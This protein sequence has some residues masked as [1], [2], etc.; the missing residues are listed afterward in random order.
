[1]ALRAGQ[2]HG[3]G[4][5]AAFGDAVTVGTQGGGDG[6]DSVDDRGLGGV[7]QGD[8][9][10]RAAVGGRGVFKGHGDVLAV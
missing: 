7:A 6:V 5:G 3:V 1:G 2:R 8:V 4:D 9:L 10:E